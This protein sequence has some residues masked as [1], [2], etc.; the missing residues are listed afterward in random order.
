M[1]MKNVGSAENIIWSFETDSS[2]G[3]SCFVLLHCNAKQKQSRKLGQVYHC[4][5]LLG[6]LTRQRDLISPIINWLAV[7]HRDPLEEWHWGRGGNCVHCQGELLT[8]EASVP[9]WFCPIKLN[10]ANQCMRK[11]DTWLCYLQC[12]TSRF[13]SAPAYRPQQ[14]LYQPLIMYCQSMSSSWSL[15]VRFREL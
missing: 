15:H 1:Y 13:R 2:V 12:Y 14:F 8:D 5:A 6:E 3:T 11:D 4:F 9:D 10:H 7:R